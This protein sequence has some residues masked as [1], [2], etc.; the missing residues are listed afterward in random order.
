MKISYNEKICSLSTKYMFKTFK[1]I[2][3]GEQIDCNIM[4]R[5]ATNN[6]N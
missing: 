1:T 3:E 4:L 2:I 5:Y 6:D